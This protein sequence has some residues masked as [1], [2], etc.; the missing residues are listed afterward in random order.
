M[1]SVPIF[2]VG[3]CAVSYAR[4]HKFIVVKQWKEETKKTSD[5]EVITTQT[6][7]QFKKFWP[8]WEYI[9]DQNQ[10]TDNDE[11]PDLSKINKI[12]FDKNIAAFSHKMFM[13]KLNLQNLDESNWIGSKIC[14]KRDLPKPQ[15]LRDLK[16]KNYPFWRIDK[17]N[18]QIISGGWHFSFLQTPAQILNKI[19]S[20]SHGEFDNENLSEIDIEQKILK[21][22]DIFGRD[23]ELK[24]IN[25]D[26][27]FPDYII[28]NQNKLKN[29]I[30]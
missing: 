23:T 28:Q 30:L 3:E 29:W 6:K 14:L 8:N 1:I 11:I 22:E 9:R 16:F 20:F 10:I 24:K 26:S 27:T 15:K 21:N 12:K 4:S 13:Y 7:T 2:F 18:Q 19:K 5:I 17:F 25:I